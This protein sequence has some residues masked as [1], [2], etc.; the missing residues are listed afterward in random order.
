MIETRDTARV[1][2]HDVVLVGVDGSPASRHALDWAAAEALRRGWSLHLVCAY[3]IPVSAGIAGEMATPLVDDD[4]VRLVAEQSCADAARYVAGR[5]DSPP[6][7]TSVAYGDAAGVLVDASEEA[8]LAVIGKRGRG[9]FASRV[10]G[11]VST[12]L[13]AHARCPTVVVPLPRDRAE[14]E[15]PVERTGV[16]VGVDGSPEAA[17]AAE[18]AA[19]MAEQRGWPLTLLCAVPLAV[20]TLAW[21]PTALDPDPLVNEVRG[22][23]EAAA[24]AMR[25]AHPRVEVDTQLAHE[26][27]ARSLAD[28]SKTAE[29]VVVG[30]RGHGG[31]TGMLLGSVS[32]AVL[33]HAECPVLVVPRLHEPDRA[34]TPEP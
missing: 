10:L 11:G 5:S 23:L 18:V 3:T 4:A 15:A 21:L 6:V 12:A 26:S 13:P 14:H 8:G 31:F 16:V 25:A 17:H 32:Q 30:A 29:L 22:E 7:R 1:S 24:Q 20:P 34:G 2:S 19:A 27:P 33:R 28:A 9:G